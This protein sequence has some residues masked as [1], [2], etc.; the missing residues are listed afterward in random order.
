RG[1]PAA[2][3]TASNAGKHRGCRDRYRPGG[4]HNVHECGCPARD[5]WTQAEA[6]SRPLTEVFHII[7]EESRQ[8]VESPFVKVIREGQVVGLAN[9]TLLISRQGKEIPIDDSGAPIKDGKGAITGVILVF[10]DITERKQAEIAQR[11]LAD[12]STVLASSLD[13]QTTLA[14]V[15][16]LV[17]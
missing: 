7:N 4:Q 17:V 5:G 9:H 2:R 8:P 6:A 1:T 16:R 13:Y 10:R 12:S 11:F 15:A 14:S 3:T